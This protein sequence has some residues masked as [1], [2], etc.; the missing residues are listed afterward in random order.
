MTPSS[1]PHSKD[2]L[3]EAGLLSEFRR[4]AAALD[5][6]GAE[7]MSKIARLARRLLDDYYVHL[8]FK[9][10]MHAID[11]IRSLR[12]LE[13]RVEELDARGFHDELLA[14]FADLHDRHTVY[15]VPEPYRNQTA[16]LPFR[17]QRTRS[18]E[19]H[20]YLVSEVT[21][22]WLPREAADQPRFEPGVELTHWNAVPI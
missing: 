16:A 9:R 19:G 7:D 15:W 20:R 1:A 17:I 8:P 2:D 22:P 4:S 11:P 18:E 5:V 6:L 21:E 3:P 12:L 14:V 10:A 13:Q